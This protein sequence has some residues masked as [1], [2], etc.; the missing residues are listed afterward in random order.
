MDEIKLRHDFDVGKFGDV[1]Y[2]LI[3]KDYPHKVK[4]FVESILSNQIR[5][6]EWLVTELKRTLDKKKENFEAK[7]VIILG[8]WYGNIIVPLL[9]KNIPEIESITLVDMDEDAM[10]LSRKFLYDEYHEKVNL[11]WLVDD[12]NFMDFD[13]MYF[14]ICINTSCEHMYPMSSIEFK[15]DKDVIYALQSN[16]MEDIREHVSCVTSA[17]ELADQANLS[18]TYF[19]GDKELKKSSGQETFNRYM[20]IG[21]R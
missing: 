12:V 2:R 8:A 4:D 20:V 21:K 19:K 14:N 18:K 17:Q 11:T 9:V 6:K 15:N 5:C 16:D 1:M 3:I 10:K 7:K 13:K